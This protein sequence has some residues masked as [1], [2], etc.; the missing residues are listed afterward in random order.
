MGWIISKIVSNPLVLIALC[1]AAFVCGG[2]AAWWLQGLRVTAAQQ[3]LVSYK[4][5]QKEAAQKAADD[6]EKARIE[7]AKQYAHLSEILDNEINSGVV[8]QRCVAAGKCGV[9]TIYTNGVRLP[10]SSGVN[11]A[12]TDSI[13]A[14]REA[15]EIGPEVVTDC[16]VTTLML[17]QLQRAIETQPGY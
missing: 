11:E 15:T 4:Q 6:A 13:P 5:A 16:A 7:S 1:A 17:N 9:R 14:G 2:S 8:Y 10:S 3:A 12:S